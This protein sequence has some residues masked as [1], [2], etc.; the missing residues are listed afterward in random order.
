[1]RDCLTVKEDELIDLLQKKS[2]F[3]KENGTLI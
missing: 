3:E 2:T 1:M